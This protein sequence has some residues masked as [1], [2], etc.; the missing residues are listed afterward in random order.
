MSEF[1][2]QVNNS[3]GKK[4]IVIPVPTHNDIMK[5]AINILQANPSCTIDSKDGIVHIIHNDIIETDIK[6]SEKEEILQNINKQLNETYGFETSKLNFGTYLDKYF[7]DL[8]EEQRKIILEDYKIK[9]LFKSTHVN[10]LFKQFHYLLNL[11]DNDISEEVIK[12]AVGIDYKSLLF[13]PKNRMTEDIIKAAILNDSRA[14]EFVH[15][16]KMTDEIIE[17][18]VQKY[19]YALEYVNPEKMTDKIIKLAIINN[20]CALQFVPNE[21]ITNEFIRLANGKD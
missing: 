15:S 8:N 2:V 5:M 10:L 21:K 19:G 18:A 14:L 16:D 9:I 11:L 4:L 7:L 20:G 3:E 13:V 6:E 12:Y 1:F 17:L